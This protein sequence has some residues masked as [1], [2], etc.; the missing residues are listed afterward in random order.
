MFALLMW[1]KNATHSQR[2]LQ[3]YKIILLNGEAALFLD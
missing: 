1:R 3:M 2:H